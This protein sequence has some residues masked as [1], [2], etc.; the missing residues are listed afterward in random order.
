MRAIKSH[1]PPKTWV[2][3]SCHKTPGKDAHCDRQQTNQA[4]RGRG[5]GG[6]ETKG[7]LKAQ[8]LKAL[9]GPYSSHL[10]GAAKQKVIWQKRPR[11]RGKSRAHGASTKPK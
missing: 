4:E 6:T 8:Q 3:C 11:E 10:S 1:P 7:M 5:G 9:H 2:F